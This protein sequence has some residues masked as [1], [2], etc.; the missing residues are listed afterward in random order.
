VL[1]HGVAGHELARAR[2]QQRQE[3]RRL[4]L[5]G[6]DVRVLSQFVA[7]GIEHERSKRVDG[8]TCSD[9]RA[10]ISFEDRGHLTEVI[11]P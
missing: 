4:R 1:N 10:A 8:H 3:S 9:V 7:V 5:Q 6:D 11:Q 2:E